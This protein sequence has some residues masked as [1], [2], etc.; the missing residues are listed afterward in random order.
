MSELE[1]ASPSVCFRW[2]LGPG[3]RSTSSAGSCCPTRQRSGRFRTHVQAWWRGCLRRHRRL[4][5]H[6]YPA[7]LLARK[8]VQIVRPLVSFH[9]FGF[10]LVSAPAGM[11][12][13][14]RPELEIPAVPAR[15]VIAPSPARRAPAIRRRHDAHPCFSDRGRPIQG[16]DAGCEP[17]VGA[18]VI[19]RVRPSLL[20]P[21]ARDALRAAES[22]GGRAPRR[23]AVVRCQPKGDG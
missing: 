14:P 17:R 3:P 7:T 11:H 9:S 22:P 4:R 2:P 5:S 20:H 21:R 19:G 15:V 13:G 12:E 18:R 16:G 1:P 10:T 6:R 23:G 8:Y